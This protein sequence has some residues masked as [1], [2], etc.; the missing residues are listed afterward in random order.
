MS[1]DLKQFASMPDFAT[2]SMSA[3]FEILETEDPSLK[4]HGSQI[5][6]EKVTSVCNEPLE[7]VIQNQ[8]PSRAP[9]VNIRGHDAIAA[10]RLAVKV[11]SRYVAALF[12]NFD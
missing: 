4:V 12:D 6:V 11:Y 5:L 10:G 7:T 1:P 2:F 9:G 3:L 8:V